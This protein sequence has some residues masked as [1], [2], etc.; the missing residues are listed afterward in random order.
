MFIPRYYDEDA[1]IIQGQHRPILSEMILND[2]KDGRKS[3]N[4]RSIMRPEQCTLSGFYNAL[5]AGKI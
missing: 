3:H 4:Q 5:L 1:M 2:V